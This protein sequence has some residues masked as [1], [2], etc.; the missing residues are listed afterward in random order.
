MTQPG[1][2]IKHPVIANK[3]LRS[4]SLILLAVSALVVAWI[5]VSRLGTT[6]YTKAFASKQKLAAISVALQRYKQDHGQYPTS[7]GTLIDP[8]Y[9]GRYFS[10]ENALNDAWGHAI[11]Y[12]LEPS[13]LVYSFGPDG[14]DDL[15]NGDDIVV[16]V[17]P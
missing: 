11:A 6:T 9:N 12:T 16:R 5:G 14:I 3:A 10:T 15:G 13:P 4:I 1:Q 17:G 2:A 7:L 8:H